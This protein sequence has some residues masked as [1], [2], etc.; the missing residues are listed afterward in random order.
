MTSQYFKWI[1]KESSICKAFQKYIEIKRDCK[2]FLKTRDNKQAPIDYLWRFYDKECWKTI[3]EVAV[4]VRSLELSK[5]DIEK[6]YW[7]IKFPISK[8]NELMIFW[9]MWKEVYIVYLLKDKVYFLLWDYYLKHNFELWL[10]KKG[11]F[12]KLPIRN[13]MECGEL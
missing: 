6:W 12:I 8:L 13:F 3:V 10:D 4:E 1:Q 7:F 11:N 9:R 2:S 5:E